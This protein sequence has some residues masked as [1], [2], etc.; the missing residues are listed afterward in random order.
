[1]QPVQLSLMPDQLPAPPPALIGQLPAPQVEAAAQPLPFR[2]CDDHHGAGALS[3][4]KSY[5]HGNGGIT[6]TRAWPVTPPTVAFTNPADPPTSGPTTA[7]AIA[8]AV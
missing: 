8:G 3:T 7:A 4:L 1:M 5:V 2:P 6:R